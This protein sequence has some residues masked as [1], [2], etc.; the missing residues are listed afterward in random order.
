[1]TPTAGPSRSTPSTHL[2]ACPSDWPS[3][4]AVPVPSPPALSPVRKQAL[5]TSWTRSLYRSTPDPTHGQLGNLLHHRSFAAFDLMLT[6]LHL[7]E[8]RRGSLL[9]SAVPAP[10]PGARLKAP[11]PLCGRE[12]LTPALGPLTHLSPAPHSAHTSCSPQHTTGSHTQ[13]CARTCT[14]PHTSPDLHTGA[15]LGRCMHTYTVLHTDTYTSACVQPQ[16]HTHTLNRM[17][18]TMHPHSGAP[19]IDPASSSHL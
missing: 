2:P 3:T 6:S 12:P 7:C 4:L 1:M 16:T 18:T 9:H 13:A 14:F 15:R 8:L 17:V 19:L 11:A 5:P 10:H